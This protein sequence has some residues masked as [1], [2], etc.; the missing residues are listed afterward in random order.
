MSESP[1][2]GIFGT[3]VGPL[4]FECIDIVSGA[5]PGFLK[6]RGPL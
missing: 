2:T 5:G 1:N 4:V 6:R 3:Y